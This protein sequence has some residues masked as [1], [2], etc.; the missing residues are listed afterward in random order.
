MHIAA[1]VLGGAIALHALYR[2]DVARKRTA[3]SLVHNT[4]PSRKNSVYR[5]ITATGLFCYIIRTNNVKIIEA[6]DNN[7]AAAERGGE[8]GETATAPASA[9]TTANVEK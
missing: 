4:L 8:F 1:G 6:H 3:G 2:N 9:S 7:T 5:F